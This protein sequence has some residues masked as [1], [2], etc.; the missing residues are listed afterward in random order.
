[1]RIDVRDFVKDPQPADAWIEP[2]NCCETGPSAPAL[3]FITNT[4]V[5]TEDCLIVNV[6]TKEVS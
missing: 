4:M 1:M 5:G 3:N 2:M 6:Y